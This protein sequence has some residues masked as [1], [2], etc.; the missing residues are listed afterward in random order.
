MVNVHEANEG[1][2]IFPYLNS[3][4]A[5]QKDVVIILNIIFENSA[6]PRTMPIPFLKIVPYKILYY[7]R[8]AMWRVEL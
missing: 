1:S 6:Y 4:L 3:I 7:D 2:Y 8:Q 5:V